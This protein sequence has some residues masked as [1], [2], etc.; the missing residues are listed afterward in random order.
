[1]LR[2][3]LAVSIDNVQ[4]KASTAHVEDLVGVLR[5]PCLNVDLLNTRVK[6]VEDCCLVA[7]EIIHNLQ[8]EQWPRPPATASYALYAIKPSDVYFGAFK[9]FFCFLSQ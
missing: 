9:R 3:S 7:S 6:N 1:M 5:D 4:K 2:T 8:N